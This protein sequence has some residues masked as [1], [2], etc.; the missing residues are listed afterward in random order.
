MTAADSSKHCITTLRVHSAFIQ[1]LSVLTS[2]RGGVAVC[3]L[4]DQVVQVGLLVLCHH[5]LAPVIRRQTQQT[6]HDLRRKYGIHEN[7]KYRGLFQGCCL[8]LS[9]KS[10]EQFVQMP[11]VRQQGITERPRYCDGNLSLEAE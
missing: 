5:K 3:V 10:A 8:I 7:A 11:G 2:L 9:V 4:D 1:R 6:L